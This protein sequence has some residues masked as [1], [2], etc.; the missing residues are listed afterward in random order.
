MA[1]VVEGLISCC[2]NTDG[3]KNCRC[4]FVFFPMI[5][6]SKEFISKRHPQITSFF[7][8]F[9]IFYSVSPLTTTVFPPPLTTSS[10]SSCPSLFPPP[11][12]PPSPPPSRPPLPPRTPPPPPQLHNIPNPK[13]WRKVK[14]A[15]HLSHRCFLIRIF[16]H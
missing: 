16:R 8:F 15:P 9:L 7:I 6:N 13:S 12:I 5:R 10:S 14:D 11:L 1:F 2:W 4:P 3:S